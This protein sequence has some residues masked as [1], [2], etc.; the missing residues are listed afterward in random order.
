MAKF[1]FRFEQILKVKEIQKKKIQQEIS[2]IENEIQ[3]LKNNMLFVMDE[4]EKVR[5]SLSESSSRVADYQSA[6]MYEKQL[7]IIIQNLEHKINEL[8]LKKEMKTMELIER[9]K[10]AKVFETLKEK[11]L[12]DFNEEEKVIELKE[13]NEIALRNYAGGES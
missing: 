13:L 11:A 10:E 3:A 6:K 9:K 12:A 5:K 8:E 7:G 2:V 1:Q 4:R